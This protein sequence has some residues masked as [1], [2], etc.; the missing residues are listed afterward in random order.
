[1]TMSCDG[2][3][4]R[5]KRI[6]VFAGLM[7]IAVLFAVSAQAQTQSAEQKPAEA[8][9][10]PMG[11][12]IPLVPTS[13][14][15]FYLRNAYRQNDLNDIQTALRNMLSRAKIY[16]VPSQNAISVGGSAEELAQAEKLISELDLL[17]K[18]Y[19]LT[20]TI[21]EFDGGKRVSSSRFS[22]LLSSGGK[23]SVK[24]GNRVPIV[25]GSSEPGAPPQS[26]QI[27]Y[28]DVGLSIEASLDGDSLRSKIEQTS[29]SEEHSGVGAQDPIVRQSVLD[30]ASHLTVGKASVLGSLDGPEGTRHREI[31]VA[32]ELAP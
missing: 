28:V 11:Y 1:M 5:L 17:R 10:I 21:T 9:P 14:Q 6:R 16:G 30:A 23:G 15:V 3:G 19:R 24:Q 31:E 29:V 4:G 18:V 26:S 22:M 27:Q 32:A 20:Y 2:A 13:N 25:T 7:L 8:K 12:P